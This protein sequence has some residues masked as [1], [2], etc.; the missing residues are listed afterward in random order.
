MSTGRRRAASTLAWPE[1]SEQKDL[2]ECGNRV[3][4]ARGM[5]EG[6]RSEPAEHTPLG[7]RKK[8]REPHDHG[9]DA[10]K[11][12]QVFH[13]RLARLIARPPFKP[14]PRRLQSLPDPNA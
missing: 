11:D 7:S 9:G 10:D 12:R 6:L 1:S 5:G 14:G 4:A 3:K 8:A 13:G 2:A